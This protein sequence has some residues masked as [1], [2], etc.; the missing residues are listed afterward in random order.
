MR[1]RFLP[2]D[3]DKILF[4][5]YQSCSQGN[6]TVHDFDGDSTNN[7]FSRQNIG[8]QS[9]ERF[10][11]MKQ[12]KLSLQNLHTHS[13]FRYYESLPKFSGCEYFEDVLDWNT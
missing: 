3:Y 4:Q 13:N 1:A 9:D 11:N 5:Q 12:F 2:P 10:I 8:S 7:N 6:R